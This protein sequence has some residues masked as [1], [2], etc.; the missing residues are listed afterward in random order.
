MKFSGFAYILAFIIGLG[1]VL[2]EYNYH[3]G[4][5][6]S[7]Y[8]VIPLIIASAGYLLAPQLD[9]WWYKRFPLKMDDK[10]KTIFEKNSEYYRNLNPEKKK[11]FD[12]RVVLYIEAK[13][14]LY[15]GMQEGMPYDLK[16]IVAFQP[17]RLTLQQKDFLL[18]PFDRIAIYPNP[19]LSPEQPDRYHASEIFEMDGIALFSLKHLM[20]SF[21]EPEKYFNIVLYEYARIMKICSKDIIFPEVNENFWYNLYDVASY[22][23]RE[24]M[25][26]IGLPDVDPFAVAVHHYFTYGHYFGNIYPELYHSFQTIFDTYHL[27]L[28]PMLR[29]D[30]EEE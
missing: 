21:K 2:F 5:F 6:V 1:I 16:A 29:G 12:Q 9:W 18:E 11:I 17:V 7:P 14:W 8:L 25:G 13:E 4:N 10:I 24:I 26:V 27:P 15:M 30:V 20:P 23:H 22:G 3:D 19:F 28:I